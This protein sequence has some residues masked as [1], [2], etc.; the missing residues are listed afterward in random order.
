MYKTLQYRFASHDLN[1]YKFAN[2][3]VVMT[4]LK[5]RWRGASFNKNN[6]GGIT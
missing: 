6:K 4:I 3:G 1:R 5:G 2:E